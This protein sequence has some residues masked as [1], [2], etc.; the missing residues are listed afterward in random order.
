MCSIDCA[1]S[2]SYP[3]LRLNFNVFACMC[4]ALCLPSSS[5]S[6]RSSQINPSS[7]SIDPIMKNLH[8]FHWDGLIAQTTYRRLWVVVVVV[9]V[10]MSVGRRDMLANWLTG[11]SFASFSFSVYVFSLSCLF[12]VSL[13]LFFFSFFEELQSQQPSTEY[14]PKLIYGACLFQVVNFHR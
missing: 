14:N 6:I 3:V 5:H 7:I 9:V 13:F 2:V 10:M 4:A 1:R 8:D 12:R 11:Q